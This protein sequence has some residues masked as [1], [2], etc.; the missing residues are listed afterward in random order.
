MHTPDF[1]SRQSGNLIFHSDYPRAS[2]FE[3]LGEAHNTETGVFESVK[4][5]INALVCT[6][7]FA[8]KAGDL[9]YEW[10]SGGIRRH[11]VQP[12]HLK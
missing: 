5:I 11:T 12:G 1:P 2:V 10:R 7:Q 4:F 3:L 8:L 9:G 6:V